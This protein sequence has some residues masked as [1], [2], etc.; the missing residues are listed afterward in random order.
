MQGLPHRDS[1]GG[2]GGNVKLKNQNGRSRLREQYLCGRNSRN[3]VSRWRRGVEGWRD[4][5]REAEMSS[6]GEKQS[7]GE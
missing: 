4:R 7:E 6:N 5:A 2:V 1:R 3:K